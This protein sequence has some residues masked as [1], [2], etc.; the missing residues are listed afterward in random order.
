[1]NA[2]R[3]KRLAC[4]AVLMGASAGAGA[5]DFHGYGRAGTGA[6]DEG[7][8]QNCFQL[9]GAASKYRLG[10][11][12]EVYAEL[13]LDHAL[14]RNDSGSELS[15]LG[16]AALYNRNDKKL[17]FDPEEGSTR[18][19]QGYAKLD[20][21]AALNGGAVWLGR[22]YYKR[23]D[24]HIADFFYWNPTGLGGG[25]EDYAIGG[26]KLSY[27]FLREDNQD[28]PVRASRHD[29]QLGQIASNAEGRLAFGLSI[30]EGGGPGRHRGWSLTVQ[31]KQAGWLGGQNT[32]ALQY[33]EGPGIG[34]GSTGPLS[35]DRD[36][37]RARLVEAFD[38]QASPRFGGQLM[39]VVQRD[40]SPAGQQ[41]WWS[42]G[43]R[44]AYALSTHLK[45]Q[46]ELGHDQVEVP[47]G[48]PR[49]LTKL[50]IAPTWAAAPGFWSRPE[51]RL[52]YTYARWNA[53]A[54]AAASPGSTL[55]ASGPYGSSPEGAS[56]GLQ[57]EHWW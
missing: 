14:Y 1:M 13:Q 12:C 19:V 18:L 33:G 49:R 22:R 47:G 11:E 41:D 27:A 2:T 40:D 31:H 57:V 30:I 50:T 35:A 44:P 10:N 3:G 54:Q 29:L 17:T 23:Q 37:G 38:W 36:I 15:V 8:S 20:K 21:V 42:A 24:V 16:M 51:L 25:V 6:A 26:A 43:I 28:Q 48:P 34:L 9:A 55:S 56:Y 45:L 32:L 53:A 4:L 5:L 7:G 39:L 52:F 46:A